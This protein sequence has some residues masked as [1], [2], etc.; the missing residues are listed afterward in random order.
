MNEKKATLTEQLLRLGALMGLY[1]T[2]SRFERRHAPLRS[3][4]RVLA[5]LRIRP[6][7][8][9]SDLA[10]LLGMRASTLN[11]LLEEL[12]KSGYVTL[13]KTEDD[14][15][16]VNVKLTEKGAQAEN[17]FKS[18]EEQIFDILSDEERAAFTEYLE[19]LTKL[20]EE[21]LSTDEDADDDSSAAPQP[22]WKSGSYPGGKR[23]VGFGGSRGGKRGE[24]YYG[25]HGGRRG[26][27]KRGNDEPQATP[28]AD[29]PTESD[30]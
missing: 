7:I 19:R 10:Y 18:K 23:G 15:S 3:R 4:T 6:E 28:S 22:K 21:Q 20:V 9:D 5:F 8:T 16:P 14:G 1:Q 12:E 26:G 11:A 27:Y 24:G 25:S 30:K 17:P 29:E 2:Q 13:E